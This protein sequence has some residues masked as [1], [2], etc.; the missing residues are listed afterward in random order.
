MLIEIYYQEDAHAEEAVS[1]VVLSYE[2]EV[3]E[4]GVEK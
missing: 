4:G 2:E 1:R 3:R